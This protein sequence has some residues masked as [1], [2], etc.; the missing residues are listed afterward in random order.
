M[1]ASSALIFALTCKMTS[2]LTADFY[3]ALRTFQSSDLTWVWAS[4]W[5]LTDFPRED[6]VFEIEDGKVVIVEFLCRLG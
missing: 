6:D 2:G 1:M 5:A 3:L 4:R